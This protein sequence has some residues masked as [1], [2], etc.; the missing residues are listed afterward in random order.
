MNL[1]V[2]R[3]NAR[4]EVGP[5]AAT[6]AALEVYAEGYRV[7]AFRLGYVQ[8]LR[9]GVVPLG[10]E[11][12]LLSGVAGADG[13]LPTAADAQPVLQYG[14][15]EAPPTTAFNYT[16]LVTAIDVR[17]A[18]G[19]APATITSDAQ[20][21]KRNANGGIT[22]YFPATVAGYTVTTTVSNRQIQLQEGSP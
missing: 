18:T 11:A 12:R 21:F 3:P 10:A 1:P 14:R 20:L 6:V 13:S 17:L 7:E 15:P 22:G 2:V 4:L 19:V 5:V 9:N 16:P 8:P